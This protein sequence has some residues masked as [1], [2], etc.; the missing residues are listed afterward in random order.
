VSDHWLDLL[1]LPELHHEH[2]KHGGEEEAEEG[3]ADHAAE[4]GGAHGSA[5]FGSGSGADDEGINPGDE[6]DGGH[7]DGAETQA[8]GFE[9]GLERAFAVVVALFGELDD[10]DG[11]FTGESDQNDEADLGE[12]VVVATGEMHADEGKEQADG[13]NQD[14]G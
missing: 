8:A 12:D 7:E 11:V 14:D 10:E 5:H 2:V 13:H 1:L 9:G 4:D 6:G 3:D